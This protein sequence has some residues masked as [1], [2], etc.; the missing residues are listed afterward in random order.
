MPNPCIAAH[1]PWR[2]RKT[3]EGT[4]NLLYLSYNGLTLSG[5]PRVVSEDLIESFFEPEPAL[6]ALMRYQKQ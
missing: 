5:L 1:G 3:E 2:I 6:R 4:F